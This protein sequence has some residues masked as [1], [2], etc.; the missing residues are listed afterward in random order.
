MKYE[1]TN[2]NN[3]DLIPFNIFEEAFNDWFRPAYQHAGSV[4][5]TDIKE[6]EKGY[7]LEVEMPGFDK[8]DISVSLEDGYLT[9]SAEKQEK[10]ESGEKK[11]YIHRE[12]S[13]SAKRSFY[14]G[15]VEEETVKA[16]YENGVLTLIVPKPDE[17]KKL[18]KGIAIE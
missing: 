13:F 7:E 15:D 2:R 1:I 11:N 18:A 4:M 16:K 10:E 5:K 9:V 17:T 14:V 3:R 8:K 12:R 6:T